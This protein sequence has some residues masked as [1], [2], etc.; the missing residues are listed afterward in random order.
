MTKPCPAPLPPTTPGLVLPRGAC[1][2]HVHVLGPYDK[3]PLHPARTYTAPE[4]P[5]DKLQAFLD[6]MGC[7]RVVIAHVTAHGT[8]MAVTL[9]A[10]RA[11]GA[12]ARGFAI[13]EPDVS[14]AELQR[15]HDGGI[16][17]TR[18]TPLYGAE[19]TA[20]TVA[21]TARRI[22]PL[23]W[24]LVYAPSSAEQWL[25][26][27]PRLAALPCDVVIDH[28]A[29]RGYAL[30]GGLD[31]P[32][33]RALLDAL[34]SGRCWLKLA[35]PHRYS[36]AAPPYRDLAPYVA[37]VLEARPDRIVWASDWPHVRVWDEAMP[38]DAD[39][40]DWI[41]DWGLD[42]ATRHRILVDNPATLYGF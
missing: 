12:R 35:A 24:H 3:Y 15:L 34:A 8:D 17:G 22:A 5:V 19:V 6:A 38:R 42:E 25:D 30:D 26:L 39:L 18:L 29:W 33:F 40:V 21:E 13:L 37:A 27:A 31:Q 2:T 36:K 28:M 4:A 7:D 41:L 23:G 16:R 32:G 10:I 20:E 9:D 1:D 14:D 11:L